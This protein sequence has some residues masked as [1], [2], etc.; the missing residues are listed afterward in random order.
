MI[1]HFVQFSFL[2]LIFFSLAFCA[3]DR[4]VSYKQEPTKEKGTALF[5]FVLLLAIVSGISLTLL[6][7]ILNS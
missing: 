2:T 6:I 3:I 4:W 5:L 1:S 7:Q